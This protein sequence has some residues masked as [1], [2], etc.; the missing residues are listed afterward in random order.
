MAGV[1]VSGGLIFRLLEEDREPSMP[2]GGWPGVTI[3]VPACNEEGVIAANVQAASAVD[4]P[5]LEILVLDDGSTDAT[6]EAAV[7]AADGDE[8]VVIV[9]DRSTA[10]RPS[11]STSVSRGPSTSSSW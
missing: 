8:R 1:W 11:G 5:E 2:E 4:Y 7:A 3:L 6:V 9:P 10:A